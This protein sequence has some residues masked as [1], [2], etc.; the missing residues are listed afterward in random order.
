MGSELSLFALDAEGEEKKVAYKVEITEVSDV[1]GDGA[2][3]LADVEYLIKNDKNVLSSLHG[4]GDFRSKECIELLKEAD[5]VVTNP[6]FSL[7]REYIGQLIKY[8]KKFLIVGHQNA[9]KYKE[10]LPLFIENK[11]WIGYGFNMSLVYKSPYENALV[12]NRKFVQQKGY[13]PDECIKVPGICW[14]TNL[15]HNKRHECLDLVCR[16]SKEDY[17]KYENYDA[18]DVK[19]VSEIPYNYYGL[20][21]VP[22]TFLDKYN[23]EQ[24]DLIGNTCDTEWLREVGVGIMGQATIDNLR[25]QGNKAHVTANMNSL[26]I[27]KDGKVSLPYAR[28]IIRNKHPQKL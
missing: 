1:N 22:I 26:Y 19:S 6:P 11:L 17:P 18:I 15:D 5:I 28:I 2:V 7:F 12:A 8:E 23:P 20:M 24:F 27:M 4:N 3:D 10:V 16:Y 25:Q 9:I 14:F 13:N 21:G